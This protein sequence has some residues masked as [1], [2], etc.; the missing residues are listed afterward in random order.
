MPVQTTTQGVLSGIAGWRY[1]IGE[2]AETTK[3]NV[4]VMYSSFLCLELRTRLDASAKDL[5]A[6]GAL[7]KHEHGGRYGV[8][9]VKVLETV[10]EGRKPKVCLGALQGC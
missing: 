9:N 1:N 3:T 5:A 6:L 2:V 8:G 4:L 10:T 7:S